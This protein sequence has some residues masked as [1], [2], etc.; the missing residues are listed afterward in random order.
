V[1]RGGNVGA[2]VGRAVM[3][4]GA[5]GFSA[6]KGAY[7]ILDEEKECRSEREGAVAAQGKGPYYPQRGRMSV[8]ERYLKD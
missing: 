7:R 3:E 6:R 2:G 1:K 8:G 4:R 5:W